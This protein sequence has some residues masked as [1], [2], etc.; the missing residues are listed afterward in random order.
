M[1]TLPVGFEDL[2][3]FLDWAL[4]TELARNQRRFAVSLED[5]QRFYDTMLPRT[6]EALEYLNQF[7]LDALTSEQRNLMYLCLSLAEVAFAIENYRETAPKYLMRI[8]RFFPV[9]D[10]WRQG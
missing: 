2:S 3:P 10:S 5:A 4:R 9:H 6:G 8:D 1:P 7:N